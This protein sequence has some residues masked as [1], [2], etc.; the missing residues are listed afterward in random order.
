MKHLDWFCEVFNVQLRRQ[1]EHL[2]C[3]DMWLHR[4]QWSLLVELTA[5][6]FVLC[7]SATMDTMSRLSAMMGIVVQ[8]H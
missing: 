6:T 5:A 3:A 8:S 2:M 7:H 4:C 1:Y